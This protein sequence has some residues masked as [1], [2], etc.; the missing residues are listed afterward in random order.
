MVP[1]KIEHY[2]LK[3]HVNLYSY[4]DKNKPRACYVDSIKSA[5]TAV[6]MSGITVGDGMNDRII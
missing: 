4:L 1:R 5:R 2:L 6:A 3:E